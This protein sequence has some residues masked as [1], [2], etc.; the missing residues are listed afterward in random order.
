MGLVWG[1]AGVLR[2]QG[3]AMH[4]MGAALCCRKHRW[5]VASAPHQGALLLTLAREPGCRQGRAAG[6]G[7]WRWV[8]L[9][10]RLSVHGVLC[11]VLA[12]LP[13]AFQLLRTLEHESRRL[14]AVLAWR[15]A[16]PV[17]WQWMVRK[18]THP[19]PGIP[20]RSGPQ[21]GSW[22]SSCFPD[23]KRGF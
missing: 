16:E 1:T 23:R 5:A 12:Q 17:F 20:S 3:L 14:E 9:S 21:V 18:P 4:W 10:I 6:A 13:F 7:C 15:R 8:Q 19:S 2:G 22:G 11:E